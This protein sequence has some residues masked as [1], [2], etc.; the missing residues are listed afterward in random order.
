MITN[1]PP[2]I[3]TY[4]GLAF[5]SGGVTSTPEVT[6]PLAFAIERVWPSP[7][8]GSVH[9]AFTLPREA[10]TRLSVLDLQGRE[11]AVLVDGA[12]PAGR[13]EPV[14]DPARGAHA[15]RAG[16]YFVRLVSEHRSIVRRL[17]LTR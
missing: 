5:V 14:W 17:A 6:A 9:I 10:D 1:L 3:S 7:A 15:P 11:I 4:G 12:L 16:V 2:A 8:A 13:H